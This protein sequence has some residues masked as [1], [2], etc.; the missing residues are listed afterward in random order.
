[1]IAA[2]KPRVW[3]VED[4]ALEAEVARRALEADFD[5]TI[6]GDGPSMLERLSE[7]TPPDVV[8]LDWH[9]PALSGIEICQF[10]RNATLAEL[11]ILIVTGVYSKT[12]D[13]VQGL[14]AGANDYVIKP[15]VAEELSAR[16]GALVRTK[17][18]SRRQLS[19]RDEFLAMLAHELR[20]PLA[21]I[22][23]A[24][25]ILKKQSDVS[26]AQRPREIMERQVSRLVRLVDDL[27]D[28]SRITR[29]Q[30]QLDRELVDIAGMIGRAVEDTQPLIDAQK[31]ELVLDIEPAALA[32]HGDP[33]RLEQIFSNL[34]NN[35]AKYTPAGGRI[36]VEAR[37]RGGDIVV[38]V[39]DNGVGIDAALQP[40][41]FDMFVQAE[42]SLARTRGGLGIGLTLVK[43]LACLH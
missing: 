1:M 24:L 37:R 9:L 36:H 41:I 39:T 3:I 27:L 16:V 6:F 7:A 29:G 19:A 21:P 32:V 4:S 38:R 35:A 14:A 8:L 15:Y 10:L 31:H 22:R 25:E 18:L 17:H 5:T 11:G 20:N 43:Q 2:A 28:I 23:T 34:L 12:R 30:I 42:T 40:R 33:V 26:E 13:M